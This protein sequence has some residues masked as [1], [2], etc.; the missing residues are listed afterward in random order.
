MCVFFFVFGK[1]K[2]VRREGG[3]EEKRGRGKKGGICG[4]ILTR[5]GIN[6]TPPTPTQGKD[7]GEEQIF[8]KNMN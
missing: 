6:A 7:P 8:Y 5:E 3:R 1:Q 2:D 4:L